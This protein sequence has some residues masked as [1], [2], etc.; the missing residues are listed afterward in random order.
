MVVGIVEWSDDVIYEGKSL[1][2]NYGYELWALLQLGL[3][4]G[5]SVVRTFLGAVK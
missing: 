5:S 3:I 2:M 1:K 4:R